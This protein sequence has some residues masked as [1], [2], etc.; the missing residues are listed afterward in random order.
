MSQ[1]KAQQRYITSNQFGNHTAINQGDVHYH[2]PHLPRPF[3]PDNAIRAIPYPRNEGM[4]DRQDLV[5]KLDTLLPG[6]SEFCS[7]ALWGLGGSGKTQIALDYAYRRCQDSKCS[8]YWVHAE[9]KATFIYDYKTIAKSFGIDP[10]VDGDDLLK[11]VRN[12]I[13]AHPP[14]VLIIDNTD[15]LG[16]FGVDGAKNGLYG[17]VPNGPA[18]TVLWTSRDAHIAGTLVGAQR[19]IEVTAMV[20]KEAIML[21]GKV[22]NEEA[23][24]NELGDVLTLLKELEWFPLAISQ[25]GAYMRRMSMTAKGYLSL[26]R[27]SKRRWDTLNT[28]E[29]D[30][31]RR[32]EMPN[33]VLETWTVSMER[34]QSENIMAYRI[35][36][37]I[38]YLDN[39]NL[40]HELIV[41]IGKF[42]NG[43][44]TG[45]PQEVD[46]M[47]AIIRLKEFS[48]L[49]MRRIEDGKPSYE[50]HKLVQEAARYKSNIRSLQEIPGQDS[51][52]RMEKDDEAYYSDIALQTISELFPVSKPESWEQCE[53]YLAH[54]IGL[55]AW[56]ETGKKQAETSVLLSKVSRYL[57][58][59]ARWKEKTPVDLRTIELRQKALGEK[60]PF[61]LDSIAALAAAYH[62]QGEHDKARD[63]YQKCLDLRR[64]TLGEKHP[65]TLMNISFLGQVYQTQ[66]LYEEAKALYYKVLVLQREVLGDNHSETL[67]TLAS[68][69]AVHHYQGH[70]EKAKILKTEFLHLQREALG[71]KHPHTLW[72]LGS[73][74]A[75]YQC[76]GE[77]KTARDL[78]EETLALRQETLGER[79][80]DTLRSL[81]SLGTIYHDLGKYKKAEAIATEA[82]ALQLEILGETHPY[83]LQ[84][85]HNLAVI[86]RSLGCRD[87][88][89][90]SLMKRSLQKF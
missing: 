5:K 31:H 43:D 35:L 44:E 71:E 17:Y 79:H 38:A 27:E 15:D 48:F 22:R 56:A 59:R 12:G 4:V 7:A 52:L 25:A 36:H 20:P 75:T 65:D 14:W 30:R 49:K 46:V 70:Y 23:S 18:G 47:P 1:S 73:L 16:L 58:D 87:A 80:P 8:V 85:M 42:N 60:H 54:A 9:N 13:E 28:T 90:I 86:W 89:A 39:Q 11:A 67:H 72:N 82:L 3:R 53:R 34:I 68:I 33:S 51:M 88:A 61:T 50:M 69:S 62:Y 55:G 77:Y 2:L 32:P 21:L 40:S 78:Y 83:S 6:G 45:Q 19:G 81:A 41:T 57:S 76:L 10:S 37:I 63:C 24:S 26:L 64:E 29:F 66:G 84:S 74:A